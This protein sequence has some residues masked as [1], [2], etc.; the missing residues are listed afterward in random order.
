MISKVR[1]RALQNHRYV[2]VLDKK[3]I[4]TAFV[5]DSGNYIQSL[6]VARPFRRKGIATGL[7]RFIGEHRGR[8]LNRCPDRMKNDAVRALSAKL[9]DEL[10]NEYLSDLR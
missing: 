4:A 6:V 2:A 9:G 3:I 7:V 5:N 10:L 8:K 1:Y